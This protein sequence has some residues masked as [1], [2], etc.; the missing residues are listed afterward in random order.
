MIAHYGFHKFEDLGVRDLKT[1][2]GGS[3]DSTC[4]NH[5]LYH[6]SLASGGRGGV[7]LFEN[8]KYPVYKI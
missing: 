4:H 6:Q 5:N 2:S 1:W 3:Q 7:V 8:D